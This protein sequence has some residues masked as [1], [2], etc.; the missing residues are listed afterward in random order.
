MAQVSFIINVPVA[1][2]N[3]ATVNWTFAK[4]VFQGATNLIGAS[5][6]AQADTATGAAVSIGSSGQVNVSQPV[7]VLHIGLPYNCQL[8]SMNLNVQGQ[9]TIRNIAKTVNRVSVVLDTSGPVQVGP[10]FNNMATMPISQFA[11]PFGQNNPVAPG[12]STLAS[13]VEWQSGAQPCFVP[14]GNLPGGTDTADEAYVCL[15]SSIPQPVTVLSWIAD[16]NIGD[17]Q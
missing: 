14:T 5:V 4:S 1:Y 3:T 2:Q 6:V 15:Q 8:Q 9:Q 16:T 7:G 13:I 17:S 10:D 12:G 11:Y